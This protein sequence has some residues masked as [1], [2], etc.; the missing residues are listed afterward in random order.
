MKRGIGFILTVIMLCV[1]LIGITVTFGIAVVISDNAITRESLTKVRKATDLEAARLNSWLT[2]Q[3]TEIEDLSSIISNIDSLCGTL[4]SGPSAGRSSEDMVKD[5]L[6]PLLKAILDEAD[7]YFE[8]YMGFA[9]GTAV[10]GS[11]YQF[12]YATW[13]SYERGWYKLA[14]TDTSRPHITSPYVDAQTGD[15]CISAVRAV[16]RDG[17]L[18]G[19]LGADIYVTELQNITLN[20]TIDSTGYSLLADENGNILVHPED[21]YSP[22]SEGN[23]KS[24]K[25]IDGGSYADLW[26]N[27][28]TSDQA[29]KHTKSNSGI[30]QYYLSA[31]LPSTGWVFVSALPTSVVS[32]PTRNVIIITIPIAI[33]ILAAAAI[34]IFITIRNLITKPLAPFTSFMKNASA[35]GDIAFR[36]EDVEVIGKYSQ[37]GDEI[38]QC[39]AAT[40]DFVTHISDVSG[41]LKEIAANNLSVELTPLSDSDILGT[42]LRDMLDTMNSTF[43]EI[44]GSTG[45]VSSVSK[46]IADGAQSLAQGSTEQAASVEELSSAVSEIAE[47]TRENAE[48]AEKAA[49]LADT[50]MINAETGSR[51][52]E[53]MISAV[54]DINQASQ[55]ISKV[56]KVIDD[57]AFQTN[58]LALNA[59]VEAARAGQYGKG[60]AVVAEEVRNLASKSAEAAKETGNMIQNSM[61]KAELGVKIAA[62]T[63][64]SLGSIVTGIGESYEIVGDIAK[65]SEEQS[66]EIAQINTGIDQVSQVVQQNSATAEQSAAASEEMSGQSDLLEG[67]VRRF[68]L[69][70]GSPAAKNRRASGTS[71][72]ISPEHGGYAPA[73]GSD[74]SSGDKY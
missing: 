59:A 26:Q 62:A 9:D 54:R 50:I 51:Q 16:M 27:L 43:A 38:G 37:R 35:T 45:H 22:D 69:R 28:T 14:L 24:L 32:Q 47:K 6:R 52:M 48:K 55:N 67:L 20:A 49:S 8:L 70:Q 63:S 33:V 36:S 57:I 40:A 25:E 31:K 17:K 29:F 73:Y 3:T 10:T 42:S 15:L 58:I 53:E 56:I 4:L 68:I 19:V 65:A 41:V 60:F 7:A 12:N 44:G 1:I 2:T 13:T 66:I 34:I 71:N 30:T 39:I 5:E 61:E 72:N 11:G 64:D 18:V 46:Q 23:F 74:N 21:S